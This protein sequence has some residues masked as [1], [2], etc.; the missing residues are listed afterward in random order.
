MTTYKKDFGIFGIVTEDKKKENTNKIMNDTIQTQNDI[1]SI[2]KDIEAIDNAI[3]EQIQKKSLIEANKPVG[4]DQTKEEVLAK[5]ALKEADEKD[6]IEF[7]KNFEKFNKSIEKYRKEASI[8]E[9][10]IVGLNTRKD[11]SNKHLS[12][13]KLK[14][15]EK[16]LAFLYNELKKMGIEYK[17]AIESMLNLYRKLYSY[18]ELKNR[19]ASKYKKDFELSNIADSE[20]KY[21]YNIDKDVLLSGKSNAVGCEI[22]IPMFN[23]PVFKDLL[24]DNPFGF[25]PCIN[26]Y[27]DETLEAIKEELKINGIDYDLICG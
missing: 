5:I 27:S 15:K 13:L 19:L 26:L 7:D 21:K 6:L 1:E 18:C 3:N 25:F 22:R 14:S 4:L 16:M 17:K 20:G 23:L 10:T 24:K 9:K 12:D 11:V 2:I 8:I